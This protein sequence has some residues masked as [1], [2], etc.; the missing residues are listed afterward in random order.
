MGVLVTML[1]LLH[2]VKKYFNFVHNRNIH[3]FKLKDWDRVYSKWQDSVH[4]LKHNNK[5]LCVRKLKC[6]QFSFLFLYFFLYSASLS[7][8]EVT[9]PTA[10]SVISILSAASSIENV[11]FKNGHVLINLGRMPKKYFISFVYIIYICLCLSILPHCARNTILPWAK[12]KH[13]PCYLPW[14]DKELIY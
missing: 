1:I 9:E 4:N 12:M 7:C 2:G 14:K 3:S 8:F 13:Y 11:H 5:Y 10:F 6:F